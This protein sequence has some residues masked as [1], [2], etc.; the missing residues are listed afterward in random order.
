MVSSLYS[1][2]GLWWF[3]CVS[4]RKV[5]YVNGWRL[6][7]TAGSLYM[8]PVHPAS[9]EK[10]NG[11]PKLLYK[12]ALAVIAHA[13]MSNY[14]HPEFLLVN[15]DI[16][17]GRT[18]VFLEI[19]VPLVDMAIPAILVAKFLREML[20]SFYMRFQKS[21]KYEQKQTGR[22][23]VA[24]AFIWGINSLRRRDVDSLSI[25]STV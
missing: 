20:K 23:L 15:L 11:V 8:N 25:L 22:R 18:L 5:E 3:G 4:S 13:G 17:W 2:N 10:E 21:N 12:S 24:G 7:S 14:K 19:S 6:S 1:K 9:I 16:R